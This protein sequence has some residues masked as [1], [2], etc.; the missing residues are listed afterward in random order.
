LVAPDRNYARLVWANADVPSLNMRVRLLVPLILLVGVS[1]LFAPSPA[2]QAEDAVDVAVTT[3]PPTVAQRGEELTV[4]ATLTIAGDT[5]GFHAVG[6]YLWEI[7]PNG[8]GFTSIKT[9]PNVGN[10]N[11]T[12]GDRVLWCSGS[13]ANV[14]EQGSVVVTLTIPSNAVTN[15]YGIEAGAHYPNAD[16]RATASVTLVNALPPVAE[17]LQLPPAF[18]G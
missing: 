5:G 11:L 2:A 14:G 9:S 15:P 12:F 18:T 7:D 6:L 16:Y 17:P 10:C 13:I 1:V 3:N 8:G 4:T